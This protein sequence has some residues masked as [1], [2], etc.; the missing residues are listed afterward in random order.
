MSIVGGRVFK[1]NVGEKIEDILNFEI[2]IKEH[3]EELKIW[4]DLKNMRSYKQTIRMVF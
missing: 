3:V 4:Y 2:K 1:I